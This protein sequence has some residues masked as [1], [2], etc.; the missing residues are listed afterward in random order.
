[1]QGSVGEIS[2][3]LLYWK[4]ILSD[5]KG[6]KIFN[7]EPGNKNKLAGVLASPCLTYTSFC[8]AVREISSYFLSWGQPSYQKESEEISLAKPPTAVIC[9]RHS[10]LFKTKKKL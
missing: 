3:Q 6:G 2:T 8:V 10:N 4:N 1:M 9:D 5:R 7:R